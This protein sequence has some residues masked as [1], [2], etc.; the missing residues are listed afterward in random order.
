MFTFRLKR[1]KTLSITQQLHDRS[2]KEDDG[3][4]VVEEKKDGEK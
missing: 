1:R 2:E 3:K 4:E